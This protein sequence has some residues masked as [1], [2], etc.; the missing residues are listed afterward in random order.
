MTDITGYD[1]VNWPNIPHVAKCIMAYGNGAYAVAKATIEAHYPGVPV[2]MID[3]NA[4]D[5]ANCGILDIERYDA[6]PEQF[7]GWVRKRLQ[8]HP[9]TLC[10][11]YM[12]LSTWPQVKEYAAELD[13]AQ[14]AQVRYWV[15]DWTG[16]PHIPE[17]AAAC[18]YA[19]TAEFDV[20]LVNAAAFLGS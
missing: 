14:L 20:S 11:A 6:T 4:T 5:P 9:G 8:L 18:Q 1:A 7:P 16:Q 10:R 15:A 3:V 2:K 12:N 13:A 19:S 17:G